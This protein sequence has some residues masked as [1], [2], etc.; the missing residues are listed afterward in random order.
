MTFMF[1]SNVKIV[2][3][4]LCVIGKGVYLETS[5]ISYSFF[6]FNQKPQKSQEHS[7]SAVI[8]QKDYSNYCS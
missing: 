2:R 5:L 1:Q 6:F 8:K 4:L 3:I 7:L